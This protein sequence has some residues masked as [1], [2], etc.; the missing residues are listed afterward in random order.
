MEIIPERW[1]EDEDEVDYVAEREKE[2]KDREAD[3]GREKK[4]LSVDE[5][6]E[7]YTFKVIHSSYA[8]KKLK[9]K[10]FDSTIYPTFN[11]MP[12]LCLGKPMAQFE[13]VKVIVSLVR[14]Y[15]F[16]LDKVGISHH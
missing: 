13:A 3:R 15:H 2:E 1:F 11:A 8:G 7:K 10:T 9:L 12:R 6:K 4:Q 14:K 5:L 16:T